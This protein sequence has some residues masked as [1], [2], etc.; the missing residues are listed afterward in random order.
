MQL[1]ADY[2]D[3]T[4]EGLGVMH[5]AAMSNHSALLVYLYKELGLRV[6]QTD[7]RGRTPLH[8][9]ALDV[10]CCTAELLVAWK[11]PINS[12]D[13]QGKTPLHLASVG[14]SA[15]N[16][17]IVRRLLLT[18]A[19]RSIKDNEGRSAYDIAAEV[20]NHDTMEALVRPRQKPLSRLSSCNPTSTAL[21]P[22]KHKLRAFVFFH[23]L[24]AFRLG[25]MALLVLPGGL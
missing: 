19:C 1:G 16:Y 25:V 4:S 3:T 15:E 8:L 17:R 23:L 13:R 21:A 11:A 6:D 9:A 2:A 20:D 14:I 24:Q 12:Q 22:P 10:S 5:I 7:N 18:G